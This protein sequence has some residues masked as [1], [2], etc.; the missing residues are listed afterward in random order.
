MITSNSFNKTIDGDRCIKLAKDLKQDN[1]INKLKLTPYAFYTLIFCL[2]ELYK[3]G[4]VRTFI[5]E[6][7]DVFKKYD[8]IVTAD[9]NNVNFIIK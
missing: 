2:Q 8:F 5:S 6:V 4:E 3:N 7:A 1:A 9:K